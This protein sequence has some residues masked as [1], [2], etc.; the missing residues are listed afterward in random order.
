[1]QNIRIFIYH[2]IVM[3][4][5][6][7]H[8]T[9]RS[10]YVPSWPGQ[11]SQLRRGP[12]AARQGLE[13]SMVTSA[14]S[15]QSDTIYALSSGPMVKCGIAVVRISGPQ[16]LQCIEA[17]TDKTYHKSRTSNKFGLVAENK[18][19]FSPRKSSL[20][21]LYCPKS[22]D[23]LDQALLLWF[24]RP[25]SFTGEDIV[26]L[27]LH[28]SRAVVLGIF[29]AMEVLDEQLRSS[30]DDA[31]KSSSQT[32]IR[33]AE[34]GEF[35]RRAFFNGKMDLTAVEG[36]ADLLDSDTS[37]QRKQALNQMDGF[38]LNIYERWR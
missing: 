3:S 28:G 23:M 34:R 15:I 21:K 26:E 20:R 2:Y 16:S 5:F 31:T 14:D 17:L 27:H 30:Y 6:L 19:T 24:P 32:T 10:F 11:S 8:R 18:V 13:R 22:G 4:I 29:N 12:I 9:V 7:F 37:E 25:N 1:M 38:M 33:P 36:L 35:T